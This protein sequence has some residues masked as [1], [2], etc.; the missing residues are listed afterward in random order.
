MATRPAAA[1]Y[2]GAATQG[3]KKTWVELLL[4][5]ASQFLGGGA[6]ADYVIAA[7]VIT[8]ASAASGAITVDTEAAAATDDLT[9]ALT[10]NLDDGSY[11]QL[12]CL[13][14]ARVTTVKHGAGGAGQ[15][16]TADQQDFVLDDVDEFITFQRDGADWREARRST[17]NRYGRA[18]TCVTIV[19]AEL[20]L[21]PADAG[22]WFENTGAAARTS[23]K[24]PAA[25][26]GA[27]P[28]SFYCGAAQ[29]FRA[30][31][32]GA[33]TIR[34]TATV[35]GAAGYSEVA[36]AIGNFF[37]VYCPITGKWVCT[38]RIGALTTV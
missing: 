18:Q 22:K 36:G 32:V 23:I 31:A 10:T 3:A 16:L 15:L 4:S 33:D 21:V 8:P 1:G 5:W 29:I 11:L 19:G 2:S 9:Y 13:T 14:A 26:K 6:E 7:G 17:P 38:S 12:R 28:F 30:N 25:I 35:S 37:D 27:G 24:L 20:Q 34:D